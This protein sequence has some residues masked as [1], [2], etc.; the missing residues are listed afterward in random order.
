MH[1]LLALTQEIIIIFSLQ[2][3]SSLKGTNSKV[4]ALT[5]VTAFMLIKWK[6]KK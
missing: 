1:K 4:G 5:I 6:P 2:M 3:E